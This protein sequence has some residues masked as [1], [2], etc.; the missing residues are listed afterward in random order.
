MKKLVL[1]TI[2]G[3]FMT[4]AFSACSTSKRS[5]CDAYSQNESKTIR[6]NSAK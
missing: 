5:K 2:V 3:L 1:V 4:A 6:V